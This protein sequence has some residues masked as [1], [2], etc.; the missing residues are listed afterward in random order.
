MISGGGGEGINVLNVLKFRS[1]VH[2]R[3]VFFSLCMVGLFVLFVQLGGPPGLMLNPPQD[4]P[5]VGPA[6]MLVI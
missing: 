2:A 4:V 1:C 3:R 5:P 6:P